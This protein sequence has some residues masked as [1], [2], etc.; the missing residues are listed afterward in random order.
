MVALSAF[1]KPPKRTK[2]AVAPAQKPLTIERFELDNGLRVVV[3][4][5]HGAPIVGVGL[6]VDV[7]ARDH[8]ADRCQ[9]VVRDHRGGGERN[10]PH[11]RLERR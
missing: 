11:A 4:P 8:L 2:A 9:P 1:A 3:Q 7:G 5:D 6:M 10:G